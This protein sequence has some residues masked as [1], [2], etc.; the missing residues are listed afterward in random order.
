METGLQLNE[1]SSETQRILIVVTCYNRKNLTIR[2]LESIKRSNLDSDTFIDIYLLDDNSPD[3]TGR[4]VQKLYPN[5]HVLFGDGNLYWGGGVRHILSH[6]GDRLM[7]Y[8]AILFANDDIEFE[9]LAIANL[10]EISNKYNAIVGGTVLTKDG[11][12]ESSGSRLGLICKPKVKLI[13]ANGEIQNC[14]MLPGHILYIPVSIFSKLN[15]DSKLKYR[16]IDLELTLRASR[17]G[18]PVLLAPTPLALSNDY[19]NYFIETSSMRGSIA[20]LTRRVLF[21]PKGP[22]WRE[23]MHYLRKVSPLMW[24][25]WFPLFY[26]AFFVAIILSQLEK[27]K[28]FSKF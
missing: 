16:F 7:M 12:V 24:W 22:H 14:Q 18:I 28:K 2:F 20:E 19:H 25:V 26:R 11:R 8:D 23:S 9:Q 1:F 4:V 6:I 21:H 15:F 13:I 17:G 3:E 5:V 10:R 27:L